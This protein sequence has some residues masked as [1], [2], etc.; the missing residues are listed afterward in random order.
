M[1]APKEIALDVPGTVT[2]ADWYPT[3]DA[4]LTRDHEATHSLMRVG[5]DGGG[6]TTVVEAGGTIGR[7][8]AG[9]SC[10]VSSRGRRST[11]D[12]A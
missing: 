6:L 12:L 3:G 11:A 2:L 4:L 7:G 10:V 9:R 1:G 5:S 8:P